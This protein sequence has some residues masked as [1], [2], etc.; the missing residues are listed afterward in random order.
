MPLT[1]PTAPPLR[2]WQ[3]ATKFAGSA[4]DVISHTGSVMRVTSLNAKGSWTRSY[5]T[6]REVVQKNAEG[7][8]CKTTAWW[9]GAPEGLSTSPFI[10]RVS[11]LCWQDGRMVKPAQRLVE[12][13]RMWGSTRAGGHHAARRTGAVWWHRQPVVA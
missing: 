7:V 12:V 10:Q 3:A 13:A 5:D 4:I 1:R 11:S 9:E 2:R 8:V 6:S